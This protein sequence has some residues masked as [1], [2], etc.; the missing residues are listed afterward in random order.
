MRCNADLI[1]KSVHIISQCIGNVKHAL[2][3]FVLNRGI[4]YVKTHGGWIMDKKYGEMLKKTIAD[5][6]REGT[7][8]SLLLHACCAPCSSYVLEY[9]ARF[10]GITLFYYNP[11]I[12]PEAEFS[13]RKSEL[14][15]FVS[16]AGYKIPVASPDYDANE[17]FSRVRG[18]EDLPEGGERCRICY[19]IRLRRTA[20]EAK[21]GG[22]D[23]FTT[24]LSISPYKNSD[25]LN[26]IGASLEKE[27]GTKY[28]YSD[29]KKN[30][31]YKRSIEL[32]REYGLYRQNYCGCVYSKIEAER[33]RNEKTDAKN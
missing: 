10:F 27:Y 30:N 5:I 22:F 23:Y 3:L 16:E 7:R 21:K 20:E 25:W 26:E 11:N 6:E 33:R 1:H 19:E 29:F 9:I 32:S 2:L 8:P 12:T 15:R 28:L 18:L 31:G 13:F 24:T 4:I 17:F 14:E